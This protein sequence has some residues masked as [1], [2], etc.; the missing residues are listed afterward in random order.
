MASKCDNCPSTARAN[1]VP[2]LSATVDELRHRVT[3]LEALFQ[4]THGVHSSWVDAAHKREL[5]LRNIMRL[6]MQM[7]QR[8]KSG[9]TVEDAHEHLLRFCA[10]A[11]V[12]PSILRGDA[13][14]ADE[15]V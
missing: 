5:A 9:R 11:G 4:Q 10:S 13:V 15:P 3:E 2:G 8:A 1:E 14:I 6:A 7:R 12:E